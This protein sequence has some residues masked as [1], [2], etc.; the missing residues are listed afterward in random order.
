VTLCDLRLCA[1][2]FHSNHQPKPLAEFSEIVRV[3][4]AIAIEIK[5]GWT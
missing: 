5:D 3:G 1:R 4:L 2:H